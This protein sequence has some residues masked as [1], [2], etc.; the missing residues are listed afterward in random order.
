MS[1]HYFVEEKSVFELRL[2]DGE[3]MSWYRWTN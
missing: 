2:S 1:L 3:M